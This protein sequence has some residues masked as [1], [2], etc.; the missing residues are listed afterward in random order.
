MEKVDQENSIACN[1]I[2][3]KLMENPREKSLFALKK[4]FYFSK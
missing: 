1:E 3:N 4:L 2:E